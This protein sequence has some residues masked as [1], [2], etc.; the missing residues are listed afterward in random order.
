M[1]SACQLIT[2]AKISIYHRTKFYLLQRDPDLK[3]QN[4]L[5]PQFQ[6]IK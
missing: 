1:A 6:W 5:H 4:V 3:F 2:G